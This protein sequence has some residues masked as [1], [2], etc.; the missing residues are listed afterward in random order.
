MI[1]GKEGP[2]RK[3]TINGSIGTIIASGRCDHEAD[4]VRGQALDKGSTAS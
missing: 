3:P 1:L 2:L 4:S